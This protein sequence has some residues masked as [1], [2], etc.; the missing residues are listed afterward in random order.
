MTT[1]FIVGGLVLGLLVFLFFRRKWNR[2][3][4]LDAWKGIMLTCPS[5]KK[6]F[7][8]ADDFKREGLRGTFMECIWCG[9]VSIWDMH[10]KPPR[11]K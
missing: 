2:E 4:K 10:M 6:E 11:L 7:D 1:M 9:H 3:E 5:C 8:A